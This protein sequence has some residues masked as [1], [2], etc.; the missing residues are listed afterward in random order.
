MQKETIISIGKGFVRVYPKHPDDIFNE[1]Y[2]DPSVRE[3]KGYMQRRFEVKTDLFYVEEKMI[4]HSST[5][6]EHVLIEVVAYKPTVT[7]VTVGDTE[8]LF[9]IGENGNF[10]L[11]VPENNFDAVFDI[12]PDDRE[13]RLAVHVSN[14]LSPYHM[15]EKA[16]S[17]D[18]EGRNPEIVRA[19]FSDSGLDDFFKHPELA[20][21]GWRNKTTSPFLRFNYSDLKSFY[22]EDDERM[23]VSLIEKPISDQ[24]HTVSFYMPLSLMLGPTKEKDV[25]ATI[26]HLGAA[27]D[28]YEFMDEKRFLLMFTY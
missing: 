11:F 24:G 22:D 5:A 9:K 4:K 23:P 6:E 16:D 20:L 27:V 12:I 28:Y 18:L 17:V 25:T 21:T 2:L 3:D 8:R 10:T 7:D 14:T 1:E 19:L 15:G 13:I 26:G